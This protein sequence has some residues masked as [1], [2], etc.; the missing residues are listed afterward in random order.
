MVGCSP[1]WVDTIMAAL[2][3]RSFRKSLYEKTIFGTIFTIKKWRKTSFG[4]VDSRLIA[5]HSAPM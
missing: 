4:V 2:I 1:I 5:S 3:S